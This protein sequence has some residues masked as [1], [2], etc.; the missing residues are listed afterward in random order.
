MQSALAD[1][2]QIGDPRLTAFGLRILSQSA[3]TLGRYDEAHAALEE[4]TALNSSLGDRWGLGAAYRGLGLVAQAQGKHQQAL[5]MFRKGLDTFTE[6]GGSWWVARVL[7]EMGESILALEDE[8]ES[9]RVWRESLRIA[10]DI[11]GTPVALEALAGLASLQMKRGELEHALELLWV[12][13]NHPASFQDTKNRA[14]QLR[15]QV[16][17]Q[18]TRQELEP[19]Q[20]RV[21]DATFASIVEG[22]LSQNGNA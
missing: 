9:G 3:F 14:S 8:A 5:V 17:V 22:I 18:L 11:H 1:C 20:Q 13:L 10:T 21:E 16:E 19:V 2:R 4:S 15:A 7:A 12:V 6:L